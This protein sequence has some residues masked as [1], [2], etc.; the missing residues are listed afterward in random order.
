MNANNKLNVTSIT[1]AEIA[2]LPAHHSKV[3]SLFM[4]G[5]RYRDIADSI[6]RPVGT[7]RSRLNRARGRIAASRAALL[8]AAA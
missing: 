8:Q 4:Q 1:E 6:G 7:V 5:M 3:L 2:A